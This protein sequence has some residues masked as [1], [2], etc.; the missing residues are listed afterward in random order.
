MREKYRLRVIN[1]QMIT[2]AIGHLLSGK[3]GGRGLEKIRRVWVVVGA[4]EDVFGRP[5]GDR[6]PHSC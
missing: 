4:R 2:E 3:S 1:L 6:V 5:S